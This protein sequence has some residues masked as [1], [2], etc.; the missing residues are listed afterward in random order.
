[1]EQGNLIKD[2]NTSLHTICRVVTIMSNER[3]KSQVNI[4]RLRLGNEEHQ[5]RYWEPEEK[6]CQA[7]ETGNS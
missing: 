6:K 4:S 7:K 5:N 1:M 3:L 2:A